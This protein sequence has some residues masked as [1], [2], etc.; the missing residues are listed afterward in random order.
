MYFYE[1]AFLERNSEMRNYLM[2][3]KQNN[4]KEKQFN[5]EVR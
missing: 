1:L 5:E 2:Y 4:F 3:K